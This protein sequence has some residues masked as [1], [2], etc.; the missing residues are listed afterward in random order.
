[1]T[2]VTLFTVT[3]LVWPVVRSMF[4]NL[5]YLDLLF[6]P[7]ES[8]EDFEPCGLL[9]PG[10]WICWAL[11]RAEFNRGFRVDVPKIAKQ[12]SSIIKI[13]TVSDVDD[14]WRETKK[15]WFYLFSRPRIHVNEFS[16][17]LQLLWVD[18][19]ILKLKFWVFPNLVS[20]GICI[21]MSHEFGT[22]L[23]CNS[24]DLMLRNLNWNWTLPFLTLHIRH[25]NASAVFL[26]V[27]T[28][29]SQ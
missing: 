20:F 25:L 5:T 28:E 26:N 4:F 15:Y 10:S 9:E 13:Y 17:C 11:T 2:T 22:S 24:Y 8:L 1:M 12:I 14:F 27:Q 29:Q 6:L 3:S 16:D 18:E 19:N 21:F 23:L 7:R